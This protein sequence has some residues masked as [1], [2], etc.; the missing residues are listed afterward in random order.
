VYDPPSTR[1]MLEGLIARVEGVDVVVV[2]LVVVVA[3]PAELEGVV[4]LLPQPV[5]SAATAKMKNRPRK[6]F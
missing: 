4:V 1:L 6:L 3:V 5:I 2:A